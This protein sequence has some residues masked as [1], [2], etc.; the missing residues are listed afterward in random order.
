[1]TIKEIFKTVEGIIVLSALGLVIL[2]GAKIFA[3]IGLA[4][5]LTVNLPNGVEKIKNFY[6][7]IK[8]YITRLIQE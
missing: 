8:E 5:Y 3:Y 7:Y 4:G 2:T 6:L 1:M